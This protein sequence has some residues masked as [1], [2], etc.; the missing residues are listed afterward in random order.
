MGKYST[1]KE[2]DDG[3]IVWVANDGREFG[4]RAGAWKHSKNLE[5]P[6]P[7]P[8]IETKSESES[9]SE[10]EDQA[11]PKSEPDDSWA[12]FDMSDMLGI[13]N[14]KACILIR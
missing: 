8:T 12:T 9:E 3:S 13:I 14:A 4:T 5:E 1:K 7:T 6:E 2:N 10:S 11:T